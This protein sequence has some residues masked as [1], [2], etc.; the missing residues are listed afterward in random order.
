MLLPANGIIIELVCAYGKCKPLE[1][2]RRIV[3]GDV[4]FPLSLGQHIKRDTD[5]KEK[6]SGVDGITGAELATNLNYCLSLPCEVLTGVIILYF[7][8]LF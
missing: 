1:G 7:W 2:K 4:T 8:I 3:L 5:E 6:Y